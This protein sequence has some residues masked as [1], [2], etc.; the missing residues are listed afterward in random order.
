VTPD[1]E[2]SSVIDW[3]HASILPLF[4]H[5]GIPDSLQNYGDPVSDCLQ[6]PA[7]RD[8][9]DDLGE[10]EQC[11]E[12]EL[13]RKRQIHYLYFAKTAALNKCHYEAL[14]HPLSIPRRC[15]F[16]HARDPWEGDNITL[17]ADLVRI[18]R[19]WTRQDPSKETGPC[20][21]SYSEEES[22]EY[23]R[24][25]QAQEEADKQLQICEDFVGVGSEGWVPVEHYDEAKQ[26]EMKLKADA[27]EAAESEEKRTRL[28]ENWIFDDFEEA[29]YM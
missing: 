16:Q 17:K 29:N 9:F 13:F 1:L 27:L 23:V 15:L 21:I 6:V 8:N 25:D 10:E 24:L 20:P 5:C 28:E 26:R 12:A 7:L 4:L 18:S 22:T 11:H 14:T 19:E 2:I 3:Q